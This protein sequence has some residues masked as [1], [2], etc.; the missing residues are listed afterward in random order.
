MEVLMGLGILTGI[1]AHSSD[2]DPLLRVPSPQV[3]GMF[4]GLLQQS[5]S[6][7]LYIFIIC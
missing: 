6:D 4:L 1:Q 3:L 5:K 7:R 2:W